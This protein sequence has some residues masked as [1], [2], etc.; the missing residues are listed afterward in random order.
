MPT[1]T[2]AIGAA[3]VRIAAC[4]VHLHHELAPKGPGLL[5]LCEPLGGPRVRVS[6][7]IAIHAMG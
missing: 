5:L 6:V 2:L 7:S 1:M 4:D 3:T